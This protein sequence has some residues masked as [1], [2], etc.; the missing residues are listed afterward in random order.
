MFHK[1]TKQTVTSTSC[2]KKHVTLCTRFK[3]KHWAGLFV[4]GNSQFTLIC[5]ARLEKKE[6]P[7]S[8]RIHW[9]MSVKFTQGSLLS[10]HIAEIS[11][12]KSPPEQIFGVCT[13]VLCYL[14]WKSAL[15]KLK[16]S[17]G[18]QIL[19]GTNT[20]PSEAWVVWHTFRIKCWRIK[21]T[22]CCEKAALLSHWFR[23]NL[24]CYTHLSL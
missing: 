9:R 20:Y 10:R 11:A 22:A 1:P 2:N 5:S 13:C 21:L 14:L 6:T 8:P 17:R 16:N 23:G 7:S 3:V 18:K 15:S 4:H 12:T 19:T 24:A